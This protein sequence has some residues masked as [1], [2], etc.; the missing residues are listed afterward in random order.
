VKGKTMNYEATAS[1]EQETLQNFETSFPIASIL[2]KLLTALI[3][4]ICETQY[5]L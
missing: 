2:S 1:T 3:L 5:A 4:S